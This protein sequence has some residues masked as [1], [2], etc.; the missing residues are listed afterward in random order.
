[1]S[2]QKQERRLSYRP[3]I[4]IATPGRLW[5]MIDENMNEFLTSSLPKSLDI[6]VLDEADRMVEV[7]HFKELNFILDFVYIKRE[8]I[9]LKKGETEENKQLKNDIVKNMGNMLKEKGRFVVGKNLEGNN[10]ELQTLLEQAE[11]IGEEMEE[12][13]QDD[14]IFDDEGLQEIEEK[15]TLDKKGKHKSNHKQMRINSK[16]DQEKKEVKFVPK[17]RGILT[18]V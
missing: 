12:I 2:Y 18:I 11:D 9:N 3:S 10:K 8:E 13:H 4:I 7:G 1:M 5:E 6:L 15:M 17:M 16:K 14:L